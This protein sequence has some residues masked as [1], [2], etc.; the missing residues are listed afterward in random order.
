MC[1]QLAPTD[2]HIPPKCFFPEEKDIPKGKNYRDN[3]ITVPA[4]KEHNL[5]TS[6]DDEY[7]WAIVAFH[8]QNTP[9]IQESLLTLSSLRHRIPPNIIKTLTRTSTLQSDFQ[10]AEQKF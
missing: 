10:R 8:W 4:C 9:D 6:K 5:K 2:D 3:L 1:D 7:I